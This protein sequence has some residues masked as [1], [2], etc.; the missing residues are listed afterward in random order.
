MLHSISFE[1]Y[2]CFKK[3]TTIEI[4]PLTILCGVNSSG[5]SSIINSL[6]MA[7]QSY[8]NS[9]IENKLELN[10]KYI[11]SG[12]YEDIIYK[13]QDG[14]VLFEIG[15]ELSAPENRGIKKSKNDIT[16][17]KTLSKLY[18]GIVNN[19]TNFKINTRTVIAKMEDSKQINNNIVDEQ[20]IEIGIYDN[21]RLFGITS[22]Y[23]K[24]NQDKKYSIEVKNMPNE[25]EFE[26]CVVF[27]DCACYFEGFKLINAFANEVKPRVNNLS[28]ILAN[29]YLIFSLN[30]MQ[31]R[32]IHYLNPLREYP[33]MNYNI[34]NEINSVGLGGEYVPHLI[35]LNQNKLING[36]LPPNENGKLLVAKRK[37]D[38][39]ECVQKWMDYLGFGH[40]SLEKNS[41]T[42]SMEIG[43]YNIIN[44]G[45]GISQVLPI[46]TSGLLLEGKETLLLEQ[47]EIHLHPK[48]QMCMADF[49]IATAINSRNIIV[50]THS[51]HIINRVIRRMMEEPKIYNQVKILFVD[52]NENGDSFIEE[53]KIDPVRGA[54]IENENFFYQFADETEKIIAVGYR[55]K[56]KE[57]ES[58]MKE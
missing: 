58:R 3:H 57:Q 40:Y 47:P 19:I 4:S 14:K 49:L 9:A 12:S 31:Y 54:I 6:L 50:E 48:A 17:F 15:Y 30:A 42:L 21:K 38:F 35:Y 43:N 25:G 33:K 22:I 46:I 55:N 53:V 23:L 44:V 36:F 7:K 37:I 41:Q 39:Q 26:R 29:I 24:H 18:T 32:S 8:E 27:Y 1:N 45:F 13:G 2:K 51:D 34:D 28:G 11:K 16:A 52:Q 5:K 10:G 56:R 20:I